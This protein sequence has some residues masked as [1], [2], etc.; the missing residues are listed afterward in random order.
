MHISEHPQDG[1]T[2]S[3]KTGKANSGEVKWLCQ[4]PCAK[5]LRSWDFISRPPVSPYNAVPSRPCSHFPFPF[6]FP[7]PFWGTG[8]INGVFPSL[9]SLMKS[10]MRRV[11]LLWFGKRHPLVMLQLS[12]V[13]AMLRVRM[14]HAL[15][16]K[17][18]HL[19]GVLHLLPPR[20]GEPGCD[21]TREE[22]GFP[23]LHSELN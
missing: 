4:G 15:T 10:V 17:L 12:G 20:W 21:R 8:F 13:L 6:P 9:Q 5:K 3:F 11:L 16:R 2:P 7:R 18:A 23:S 19:Q 14:T 22:N 1:W